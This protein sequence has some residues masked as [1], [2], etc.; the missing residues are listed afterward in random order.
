MPGGP[1]W[2][3]LPCTSNCER[4]WCGRE[5]VPPQREA[6]RDTPW[7]A[8]DGD[9]GWHLSHKPRDTGRH[10]L[11]PHVPGL[12]AWN[13]SSLYAIWIASWAALCWGHLGLDMQMRVKVNLASWA[14]ALCL[15][16]A[17]ECPH[18]L[19]IWARRNGKQLCS[20][21]AGI[22]RLYCRGLFSVPRSSDL[23]SDLI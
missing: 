6:A 2:G 23:P 17:L 11:H 16:P 14:S 5:T 4:E 8:A 15:P 1:G 10:S 13:S 20:Y 18:L 19:R 7:K 3:V 22:E 12:R 21:A 9:K